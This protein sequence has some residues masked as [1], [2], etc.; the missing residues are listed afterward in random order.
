MPQHGP[1]SFLL[2]EDRTRREKQK[3]KKILGN[4]SSSTSWRKPYSVRSLSYSVLI[5]GRY[6]YDG[7]GL[8]SRDELDASLLV[9]KIKSKTGLEYTVT[10]EKQTIPQTVR[11]EYT[12]QL[13]GLF[14]R[15]IYPTL[16]MKCYGRNWVSS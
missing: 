7:S 15:G 11:I 1:C 6:Y 16:N 13:L 9:T 12:K 8:W 14:W 3:H 4:F 5:N 2:G 10:L